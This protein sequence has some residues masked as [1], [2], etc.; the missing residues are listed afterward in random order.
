MG[1]PALSDEQRKETRE[2]I[3]NAALEVYR[4]QGIEGVSIRNVAQRVGLAASAIYSYFSSRQSLVESLWLDPAL[5]TV[6]HMVDVAAET[7]DPM[8]RIERILQ[9]YVD[10]AHDNPDVYRGAFMFVR[11]ESMEP[12]VAGNLNDLPFHVILR[13]AISEAQKAGGAGPGD[14]DLT[15]Q[16]LWAGVHGALALGVNIEHWK[17]SDSR[18]MT[19]AAI[20]LL[21]RGLR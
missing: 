6:Q 18:K 11:P 13:D 2:R 15:A 20:H 16:A 12:P 3:R 5:T 8:Q 9:I 1:R 7:S 19:Q 21:L 14:P 4:E 17:F 10:F